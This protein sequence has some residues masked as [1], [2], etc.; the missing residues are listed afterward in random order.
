MKIKQ[1][2]QKAEALLVQCTKNSITKYGEYF[3]NGTLG[4]CQESWGNQKLL[5]LYLT[6]NLKHAIEE[7]NHT[8]EIIC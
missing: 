5:L 8:R 7:G 6:L 1:A 3:L 2:I 4:P